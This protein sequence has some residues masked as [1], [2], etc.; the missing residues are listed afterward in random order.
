M[1][2]LKRFNESD[3]VQDDDMESKVNSL[4]ED[5]EVLL[6]DFTDQGIKYKIDYIDGFFQGISFELEGKIKL[7]DILEHLKTLKD[8]IDS[9]YK[10]IGLTISINSLRNVRT[11]EDL[12]NLNQ[13]IIDDIRIIFIL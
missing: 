11:I 8:L 4:V 2:Y 7:N 12:E 9:K 3:E 6:L 10:D 1:K 5:V 13:E